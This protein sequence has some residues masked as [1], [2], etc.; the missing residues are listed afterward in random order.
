VELSKAGKELKI[1]KNIYIM[2]KKLLILSLIILFNQIN[3][4]SQSLNFKTILN[5]IEPLF[6]DIQVVNENFNFSGYMV[7]KI[8][9]NPNTMVYDTSDE[10]YTCDIFWIENISDIIH[11]D[12]IY[13]YKFVTL[14]YYIYVL[15]EKDKDTIGINNIKFRDVYYKYISVYQYNE[16]EKPFLSHA[17]KTD[18]FYQDIKFWN[19]KDCDTIGYFIFSNS[20]P[21][22]I[23]KADYNY[24]DKSQRIAEGPNGFKSIYVYDSRI[25]I[26]TKKTCDFQPEKNTFLELN[27]FVESKWAPKN[28]YVIK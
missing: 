7:F 25:L 16:T 27:G 28:L 6:S 3:I 26:P 9:R 1:I 12:K 23:L 22:V 2:F 8:F 15:H 14:G 5:P 20:F 24:L 19:Y 10:Y 13:S 17:L 4:K 11:D 21:A 18:L